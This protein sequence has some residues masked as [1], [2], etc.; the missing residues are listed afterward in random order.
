MFLLRIFWDWGQHAIYLLLL[1]L[2]CRHWTDGSLH[3]QI[4]LKFP[5]T[6]LKAIAVSL[7]QRDKLEFGEVAKLLLTAA[8]WQRLSL[9]QVVDVRAC[10]FRACAVRPCSNPTLFLPPHSCPGRPHQSFSPPEVSTCKKKKILE[11]L[12]TA[13]SL[14][15]QPCVL[16]DNCPLFTAPRSY[17]ELYNLFDIYL[18]KFWQLTRHVHSFIYS[19]FHPSFYPLSALATIAFDYPVDF[20]HGIR[21]LEQTVSLLARAPHP[22]VKTA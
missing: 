13:P 12:D 8:G 11:I 2:C 16:I 15:D 5:N 3:Y 7:L 22:L 10:V 14:S 21:G 9:A 19:S 6:P 20:R 4:W 17:L 18:N 1:F